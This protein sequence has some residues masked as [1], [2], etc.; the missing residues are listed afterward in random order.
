MN[1][2]DENILA[3]Q[4]Q[5]LLSWRIPLHQI[6]YD[7]TR[8]GLKDDNLIPFLLTLRLPTF[9][10]SDGDFYKRGLCHPRYCLVH[11]AMDE[12]DT[13]IFIRRV[14]RHSEFNTSA[15]R[16]GA[17]IQTSRAGLSVWRL[18]ANRETHYAWKE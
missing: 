17:V 18:H 9:F 2:L 10:T 15:K 7:L 8:K 16:M 1:V 12:S 3:D 11:M 4:R 14:L 6:G 5:L 13:A